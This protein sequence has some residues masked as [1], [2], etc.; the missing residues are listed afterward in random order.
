[1]AAAV[2]FF[3]VTPMNAYKDHIAEDEH[4]THRD[5]PECLSEVPVAATRCAHCT[6][7]LAQA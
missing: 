7:Q 1:V 6:T 4:A 5:C 3:I 2:Y